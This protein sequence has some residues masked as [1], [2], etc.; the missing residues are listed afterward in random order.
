MK[1][2]EQLRKEAQ[3]LIKAK[4]ELKKEFQELTG[5]KYPTLATTDELNSFLELYPSNT[6][7]LFNTAATEPKKQA[8]AP[9]PA[10]KPAAKPN[11]AGSAAAQLQLAIEQ[12]AAASQPAV[13]V[14][15]VKAI[16]K[17]ELA[18]IKPPS[19]DIKVN[20]AAPVNVKSS[21]QHLPEVVSALA[22]RVNVFLSGPA[23]TGKTSIA[24]EVAKA[25]QIDA[26]DV[27]II[28]CTPYTTKAE[29]FGG[30]VNPKTGETTPGAFNTAKLIVLDEITKLQP[31]VAGLL[32]FPLSGNQFKDGLTGEIKSHDARIIATANTWGTG[33]SSQYNGNAKQDDSLIDSRF[34]VK[35]FVDY[36][37]QYEQA[38]APA[39]LYKPFIALRKNARAAGIERV[40]CTRKL[41]DFTKLYTADPKFWSVAKII[42]NL[43][44]NWSEN[45]KETAKVA[46]IKKQAA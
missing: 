24:Y 2:L 16:V 7:E 15:D 6:P 42:D 20:N 32:N 10:Q 9:A 22:N 46:T 43:T 39:E 36:S 18:G 8:P 19:I 13:N 35:I 25:L 34:P 14:D 12:I 27:Q 23:G 4:P 40:I 17:Q 31:Q 1:T 37:E 26:A 41:K 11:N 3:N 21:Y 30:L 29:L 28:T 33:L 5:K 44:A 45:E 38:I